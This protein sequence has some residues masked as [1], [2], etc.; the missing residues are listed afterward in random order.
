MSG[1]Y[2]QE[3]FGGRAAQP[4]GWKVQGWE[5]GVPGMD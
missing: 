4:L 5:Q 3:P 1:L 2:R